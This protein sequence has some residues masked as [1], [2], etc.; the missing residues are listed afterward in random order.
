M[1]ITANLEEHKFKTS[2][3]CFIG[4]N[5][6]PFILKSLI[7]VYLDIDIQKNGGEKCA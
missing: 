2:Y 5:S 3:F 1:C 7:N 6:Q 4:D